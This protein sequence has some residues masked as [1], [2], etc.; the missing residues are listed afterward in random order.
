MKI[1]PKKLKRLKNKLWRIYK[2]QSG[3]K[4]KIAVH[5]IGERERRKISWTPSNIP[6]ITTVFDPDDTSNLILKGCKVA[7]ITD[8]SGNGNHLVQPNPKRQPKLIFS[9]IARY[10]TLYEN[11]YKTWNDWKKDNKKD[12]TALLDVSPKLIYKSVFNS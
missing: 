1:N 8:I 7:Q 5:L 9:S 11:F 12:L 3:I 6:G 2:R 10:L 4:G